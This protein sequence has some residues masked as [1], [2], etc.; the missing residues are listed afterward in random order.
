MDRRLLVISIDSMIEDD[1]IILERLDTFAE[2]LDK[3]SVVQKMTSTYPTLTHSIHASIFTGCYPDRHGIISNERFIPGNIHAPWFDK[4]EDVKV[5]TL[6]ELA[7]KQ[8]Y[9]TAYVCWPL[10][11]GADAPYVLHR[12]GIRIPLEQKSE[13]MRSLSTAGL[14]DE[15]EQFTGKCWE[16]L[17]HF[18]A[19]DR[20]SCRA[21][22]YLYKKYQPDIM[23]VHLILIDHVRHQR[24]VYGEHIE[25]AYRFLDG[26]LK[27][28]WDTLKQQGLID[29][30]IVNITSD[31]GH[32]PVE[33]VVSLNRFFREQGLLQLN[34]DGTLK[35]W[36]AYAHSCALSAHIYLSE[37]ELRERV[38]SLLEKNKGELGI[39]Q[40]F[41]WEQTEREYHLNGEFALVVETDGKTAFSSDF[42][43]P[44]IDSTEDEDYRYSVSTHGHL[45]EVGP[46]PSFLL[47]NPFAKG[48][49]ELE[50]GRIVDQ[51]PTLAYWLGLPMENCDGKAIKELC[52]ESL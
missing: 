31:H 7:Q 14:V 52:E 50:R 22:A 11:I 5:E 51:A 48:K 9:S 24:G 18:E 33:R 29:K 40:V 28:L 26:E 49:V 45:P 15:V 30:I 16:Q 39:S 6:P 46:Q 38:Y 47:F 34:E 35:S 2:I 42:N 12:A 1:L 19:S 41:T 37:S 27:I 13:V 44:L 17:E 8:G 23:Y 36:K 10:T 4:A 25:Q 20:F 43:A 3:S 21:C 32:L